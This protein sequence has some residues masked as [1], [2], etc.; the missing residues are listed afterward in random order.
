MY[1]KANKVMNLNLSIFIIVFVHVL[2][3]TTET[4]NTYL[5]F[6]YPVKE[7]L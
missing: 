3:C 7:I 5:T 6:F 2:I 1:G 4:V